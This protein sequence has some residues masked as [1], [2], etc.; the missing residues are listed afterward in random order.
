MSNEFDRAAYVK[1]RDEGIAK[2]LASA[3]KPGNPDRID[4]FTVE[5]Y[6]D[7][8]TFDGAASEWLTKAVMEDR[9]EMPKIFAALSNSF[10]NH[11]RAIAN[12]NHNP[13][14]A[15]TLLLSMLLAGIKD[16]MQSEGY[17]TVR[18]AT[19]GLDDDDDTPGFH[20]ANP[21]TVN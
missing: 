1:E 19:Q 4:L 10:R 17:G 8:E 20:F 18:V 7:L 5:A 2:M 9:Y 13:A 16:D 11:M 14:A 3:K 6:A 15:Y 12:S 21:G